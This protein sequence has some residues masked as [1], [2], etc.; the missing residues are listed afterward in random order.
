M[1]TGNILFGLKLLQIVD[2]KSF[3]FAGSSAEYAANHC[4]TF[5]EA[6]PLQTV[7]PYGASKAAGGLLQLACAH[8][9]MKSLAYLR[10]F[11]VYGPGEKSHRLTSSLYA[12]LRAGSHVALSSGAQFRDFVFID[13]AIAAFE[14]AGEALMESR[15]STGAYNVST[16]EGVSVREACTLMASLMDADHDLLGFGDLPMRQNELPRVVG[17]NSAFRAATGWAPTYS[18]ADGLK[19]LIAEQLNKIEPKR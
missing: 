10:F 7:D 9:L 3:V 13:D 4:E 15:L 17:N 16:G 5:S 19:C 14:I 12:S 6:D 2:A 1:T 8:Q 18:L 11:H